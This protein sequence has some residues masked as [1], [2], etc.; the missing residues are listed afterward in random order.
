LA[1]EVENV[2]VRVLDGRE[3]IDQARSRGPVPAVKAA[4]WSVWATSLATSEVAA[5]Y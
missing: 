2:V 5:I 3:L 4:A 1:D